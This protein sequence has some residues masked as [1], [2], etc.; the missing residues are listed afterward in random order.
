M[1]GRTVCVRIKMED[2]MNNK[3]K[4]RNRRTIIIILILC[5]MAIFFPYNWWLN[6]QNTF[7]IFHFISVSADKVLSYGEL[8]DFIGGLLGTAIAGITCWLVYV[9]YKSQKEELKLARE[10]T[11]KQQFESTFFNL[12]SIH[13]EYLDAVQYS[14]IYISN[15]LCDTEENIKTRI[16][17]EEKRAKGILT[18]EEQKQHYSVKQL[19]G[20]DALQEFFMRE[21]KPNIRNCSDILNNFYTRHRPLFDNIYMTFKYLSCRYLDVCGCIIKKVYLD[22]YKEYYSAQIGGTGLL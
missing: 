7:S 2:A 21:I 15:P 1:L 11:E 20:E 5:I 6:G 3:D 14:Q 18:A 4:T 9:T 12:V 17:L 8:G 13:K 16:K 22:F 19:Y 10:T